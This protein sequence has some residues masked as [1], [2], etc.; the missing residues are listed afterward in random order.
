MTTEDLI[1][2]LESLDTICGDDNQQQQQQQQQQKITLVLKDGQ[3]QTNKS[4]LLNAP[5][6]KNLLDDKDANEIVLPHFT[7]DTMQRI[8]D[9][10]VHMQTNTPSLIQKPLKTSDFS[11]LLT[12]WE[13]EFLGDEQAII[14]DLILAANYL[15]INSLRDMTCAKI[16]SMIKGKSPDQIRQSF[17]IKEGFTKEEE[18]EIQ[19][20]NRWY[21]QEVNHSRSKNI[22]RQ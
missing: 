7:K 14:F 6:L 2:G 8:I 3:I 13:N 4:P 1:E 20:E 5:Y 19:R 9:Y 17:N 22:P 11:S 15:D 12:S 21:Y 18:E 16:A 10:L